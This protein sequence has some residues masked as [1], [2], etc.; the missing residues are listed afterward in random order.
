M[1]VC[2]RY[3]A[4]HIWVLWGLWASTGMTCLLSNARCWA[5]APGS[6]SPTVSDLS[7]RAL[8]EDEYAESLTYVIYLSDGDRVEVGCQVTNMGIGNGNGSFNAQVLSGGK[9]VQ[10]RHEVKHAFRWESSPYSVEMGTAE[11]GVR[12]RSMGGVPGQVGHGVEL[13]ATAP[14]FRV[15]LTVLARLPAWRPGSGRIAY[16]DRL[17]EYMIQVPRA[18]VLG[19]VT[20]FGQ[21]KKV[22][23]IGYVERGRSNVDP[24]RLS[25]RQ[26]RLR[27][28]DKSPDKPLTILAFDQISPPAD[29]ERR[30]GFVGVWQGTTLVHESIVP[31]LSSSDLRPDPLRKQNLVPWSY[32]I[33]TGNV[34]ISAKVERTVDRSDYLDTMSALLRSIVKHFVHPV[35]YNYDCEATVGL[36]LGGEKL[37]RR[38]IADCGATL[39]RP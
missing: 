30:V 32:A 20:A 37:A 12:I 15:Q 23:G 18:E 17:M 7:R 5:F 24:R 28:F 11:R 4:W 14:D 29:G 6:S 33:S 3:A 31:A 35:A 19:E 22:T 25:D 39:T 8:P 10:M 38:G 34:Q 36:S 26:L 2:K 13:S 1:V 21:T 16:G 27:F 9:S